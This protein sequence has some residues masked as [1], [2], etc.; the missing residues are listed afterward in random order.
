M[1]CS[2]DDA[3]RRPGVLLFVVVHVVRAFARDLVVA[4]VLDASLRLLLLPLELVLP[5][6]LLPLLLLL[7]APRP[8]PRLLL[9]R[10]FARLA[11]QRGDARARRER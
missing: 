1:R 7:V 10:R 5:P 4:L 11:F 8:P 9:P 3:A 6:L 2:A